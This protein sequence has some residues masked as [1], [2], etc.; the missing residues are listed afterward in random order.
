LVK[1]YGNQKGSMNH[2]RAWVGNQYRTDG[3]FI[4]P[5]GVAWAFTE[6]SGICKYPDW[7]VEQS[8][9]HKD[10]GGNGQFI[11]EGDIMHVADD[12]PNI[13]I[14]PIGSKVHDS[15]DI[16]V[17]FSWQGNGET[18]PIDTGILKGKVIGN[19]HQNSEL[20]EIKS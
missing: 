19:I 5:D 14:E 13:L 18:I 12:M 2:I 17:G 7:I 4:A 8:I 9:G 3:F 11:F 6:F 10:Q 20:L 15:E 1:Q 16:T